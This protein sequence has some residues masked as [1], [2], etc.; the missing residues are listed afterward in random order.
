MIDSRASH[1]MTST[2]NL[3]SLYR[4]SFGRDKIRIAD[5]SLSSVAGT[6]YIPLT[7]S[8]PLFSVFHVSNF[9]LNLI[10]VNHITKP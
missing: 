4:V 8:L 1:H 7:S 2:F 10:S 9:K 3:F 5:G 6:D